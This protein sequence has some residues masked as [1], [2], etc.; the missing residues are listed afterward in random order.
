MGKKNK[1]RSDILRRLIN[2]DESVNSLSDGPSGHLEI[3]ARIEGLTEEET[4][5]IFGVWDEE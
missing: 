2:A 5:A 1:I 4:D 3:H